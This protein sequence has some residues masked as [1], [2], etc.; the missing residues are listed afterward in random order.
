VAVLKST[1]G[2]CE[3]VSEEEI[4]RAKAELGSDGAGCEPASAATLGGLKKLA[5]SGFVKPNETVVLV[6]TGHMLKDVDY[7]RETKG[8]SS[9]EPVEADA[10]VV[11]KRLEQIDAAN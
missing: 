11:I 6:L 5:Q 10:A 8:R 1:G 2:A 3:D 7:M 4:A 9:S